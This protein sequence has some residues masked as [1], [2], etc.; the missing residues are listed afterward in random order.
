MLATLFI[1]VFDFTL[2]YKTK[3]EKSCNVANLVYNHLPIVTAHMFLKICLYYWNETQ[4]D[5]FTKLSCK[6]CVINPMAFLSLLLMLFLLEL[7]NNK[8]HYSVV[9]NS[10][11][12]GLLTGGYNVSTTVNVGYG[13]SRTGALLLLY[14]HAHCLGTHMLPEKENALLLE[15]EWPINGVSALRCGSYINKNIQIYAGVRD[16]FQGSRCTFPQHG[17]TQL[18]NLA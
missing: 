15:P 10:A 6:Y 9:S 12:D 16:G 11:K 18:Q 5:A 13:Y 7:R 8:G 17:K 4:L 2:A 3:N 1:C 14:M